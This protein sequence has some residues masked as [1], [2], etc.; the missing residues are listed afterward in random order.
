MIYIDNLY[1]Y[2]WPLIRVSLVAIFLLDMKYSTPT[3]RL[4]YQTQFESQH[5]KISDNVLLL[6]KMF[7]LHPI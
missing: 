4:C 1:L 5:M 2:I 6:S 3:I 7:K